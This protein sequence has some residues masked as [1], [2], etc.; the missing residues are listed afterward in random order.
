MSKIH[1][2]IL[3]MIAISVFLQ[4][5]INSLRNWKSSDENDLPVQSTYRKGIMDVR[6]VVGTNDRQ[7]FDISFSLNTTQSISTTFYTTFWKVTHM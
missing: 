7:E 4:K 1:F 6:T 5:S 3:I 2:S